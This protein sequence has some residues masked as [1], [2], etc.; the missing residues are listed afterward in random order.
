MITR[1]GQAMHALTNRLVPIMRQDNAVWNE[2]PD[3]RKVCN[4]KMPLLVLTNTTIHQLT[5]LQT[6]VDS[7]AGG[8][9]WTPEILTQSLMGIWLAASFQP[10]VVSLQASTSLYIG[11]NHL[12]NLHFIILTLCER[13]EYIDMLRTE[14]DQEDLSGEEFEKLPLLD[15]FIK[16]VFRTRPLDLRKSIQQFTENRELTILHSWC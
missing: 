9:Y 14:L 2:N 10:W 4:P 15:S 1:Q 7:S 12:Q 5:L 8:D 6:M 16:E 13:P 11:V 3:I